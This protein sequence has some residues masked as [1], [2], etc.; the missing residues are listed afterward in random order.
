MTFLIH[1]TI[2]QLS[3]GRCAAALDNWR[4]AAR[5]VSE[6]WTDYRMAERAAGAFAFRAYIAALDAEEAAAHELA[7]LTLRAAA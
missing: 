2:S 1:P 4:A 3:G 6:R 5:V 7:H